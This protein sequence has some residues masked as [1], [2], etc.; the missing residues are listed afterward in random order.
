MLACSR[1]AVQRVSYFLYVNV[2]ESVCETN[3]EQWFTTYFLQEAGAGK[4]C[5]EC[6]CGTVSGPEN[7]YQNLAVAV[8]KYLCRCYVDLFGYTR[9]LL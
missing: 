6:V 2:C 7:P 8:N 9:S 3:S 5:S 1:A 4:R